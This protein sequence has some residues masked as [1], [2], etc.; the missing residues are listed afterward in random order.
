M[1]VT[2][3]V[4]HTLLQPYDPGLEQGSQWHVRYDEINGQFHL[5]SN[6]VFQ[7]IFPG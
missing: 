6:T 7:N 3:A 1:V 4:S 2:H 5:G